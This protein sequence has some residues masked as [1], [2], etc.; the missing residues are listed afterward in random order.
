MRV[1]LN[2]LHGLLD[3]PYG[4]VLGGAGYGSWAVFVNAGQGWPDALRIGLA[5]F[6]MSAGLTYFGVRVMNGLFRQAAVPLHGAALACFGSLALTYS[7]LIGVHLWLGTP[8]LFLTLLPGIL[9]TV[10]FCTLY[11]GLLLRA[12]P[13]ALSPQ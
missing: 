10:S 7:L 6:A 11:S 3:S 2:R 8:H 1:W 12:A 4:A 9:P 5:H 13:A